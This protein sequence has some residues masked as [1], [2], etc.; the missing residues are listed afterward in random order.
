MQIIE[1]KMEKTLEAT[2]RSLASIR[3]GRATPELLNSVQVE[4]YGT[5][6]PIQQLA[7]IT[8]SDGTTLVLNV[9]DQQAT[10]HVEKAL[11]KSN[12]GI[13]PQR[14]GSIIRLRLPDLT[15]ERRQEL[16]KLVKSQA[17]DGKVSLRHIRRDYLDTVKKSDD[18]S[19]DEIKFIQDDVQKLTDKFVKR[20]DEIVKEKETDILTV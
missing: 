5:T 17:E 7:N 2:V 13:T 15:S 9:F 18:H 11:Q 1:E 19:E 8:V 12:L 3:T 10:P 16:I 14:D 20:I 4:Y 6:L